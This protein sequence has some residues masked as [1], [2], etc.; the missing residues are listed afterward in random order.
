MKQ[1]L[2]YAFIAFCFL[3]LNSNAQTPW[4]LTGNTPGATDFLGST[5]TNPLN[6][7]TTGALP[8]N[9][10]TNNTQYMTI[11]GSTNPGYVGIGTASPG[12]LLEVS[13]G[14]I[15]VSTATNSFMING[16]AV[17]KVRVN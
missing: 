3:S 13:G 6:L 16:L 9:F 10:F 8:I 11:L 4:Y 5:G 15:N 17:K 12:Q 2:F 1:K 14:N 7:K